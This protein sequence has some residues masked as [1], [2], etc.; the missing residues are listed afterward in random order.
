MWNENES[1]IRVCIKNRLNWLKGLDNRL[2]AEWTA[3]K[4]TKTAKFC[5][6]PVFGGSLD[7]QGKSLGANFEYNLELFIAMKFGVWGGVSIHR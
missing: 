3:Y 6:R 2:K 1:A 7:R 5:K 4:Q